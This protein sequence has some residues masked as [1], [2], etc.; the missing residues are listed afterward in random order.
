MKNS[1]L[2]LHF[3]TS[4]LCFFIVVLFP[5][6]AVGDN[7][8]SSNFNKLVL[9][10]ILPAPMAFTP[11]PPASDEFWRSEIPI[12]MRKDYIRYGEGFIECKWKSIDNSIFAE[13]KQN[14]NRI[15]YERKSFSLREQ[16][17]SLVMA[18]ILDHQGRFVDDITNGLHYF[19]QEVWWGIPAHYP[20]AQPEYDEQIVDLFNAETAN[21]LAWTTYMLHNEIENAEEGL[22]EKI[23]I[24]IE[25]RLLIPALNI[26]YA[27]K[28]RTNNWNTWICSNW[29]SCVLFC[30]KERTKQI[31][32]IYQIL[33]CLDLFYDAYPQDGGCEE[34]IGYWDRSAASLFE[35][36][37][38]F[39]LATGE[40]VPLKSQNKFK[41]MGAF[42]YNTY[43]GN[44]KFVTFS[45]ATP[46]SN[47]QPNIAL[48]FAHY[49]HDP[50]LEGYAI[51]TATTNSFKQSPSKLFSR[52][53]NYP[54]LSREILFLFQYN[55]FSDILPAEPLPQN[56][57]MPTS[58]V[59]AARQSEG[60]FLGL[61]I[62]AKGGNN[63]ESHNHNDVGNFVVYNDAEPI[64]IDIGSG[65]YTAQSFS[66]QRYELFNCRSAYHNVP[67]IN[68]C[69]QHEGKDYKAN[70]VK[71]KSNEKQSSLT[72]DISEA[73]PK[74]AYVSK[75][76]RT[77]QLNRGK[78][79]LV[80]EQFKL[81]KYKQPCEI[82]LICCGDARLEYPNK[83]VINNGKNKGALYFNADQL[84]PSIE[85]IV[86]HDNAIL[87]AWQKKSLFRI[88]LSLR[89]TSLKGTINYSI[90]QE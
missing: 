64:I 49:I 11:V 5:T 44:D 37:Y 34:G 4:R 70:N 36:L 14:G 26:N 43:I 86:F 58:Q 50:L 21:L 25:R 7:I 28:K 1:L 87:N 75:W 31:D 72:L 12:D 8:L 56:V 20:T 2:L 71:Y 16:L 29:L 24:E 88:R 82:I 17:A 83:I 62:A 39:E 69:E 78:E 90:K 33:R 3:L 19:I 89:I 63:N 27:W 22:C 46:N 60:S 52:S 85:K 84:S 38:L 74:E 35:S 80:T 67:I 61:Y 57:W 55:K 65:T 59:F 77:I 13:Y 48:P 23:R 53:G 73:Y 66:K 47:I 9:S 32:A 54:T 76:K 81:K 6:Y 45:D 68:G 15:N 41:N 40:N 30:E 42:V 79:V 10:D 18:E 51:K